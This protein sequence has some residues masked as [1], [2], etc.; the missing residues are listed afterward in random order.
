MNCMDLFSFSFENTKNKNW[1][2]L[3]FRYHSTTTCS[4]FS[5]GIASDSLPSDLPYNLTAGS[6]TV[7]IVD[8]FIM[9]NKENMKKPCVK[10]STDRLNNCW[11]ARAVQLKSK[12]AV[13]D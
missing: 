12:N 5:R 13:C 11:L 3:I 10:E 4:L 7:E 1:K 6:K 8:L 2:Y 9:Y